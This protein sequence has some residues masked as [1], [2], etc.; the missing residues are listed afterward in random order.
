MDT[1]GARLRKLR[2]ERTD[3]SIED[4]A[5]LINTTYSSVGKYERNEQTPPPDKLKALAEL[6]GTT[7]DY[8]L[9][10]TDDPRRPILDSSTP[11]LDEAD[12]A[13]ANKLR[14]ISEEDRLIIERIL[15]NAIARQQREDELRRHQHDG[16]K[17]TD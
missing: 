6:Y 3:Y 1:I 9:G 16:G 12:V 8:I 13:F 2:K 11:L 14:E 15:E 5:R 10:L 4:V 7:T 17:K